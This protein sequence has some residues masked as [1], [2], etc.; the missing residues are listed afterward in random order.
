[1][2]AV[3]DNATC[4]SKRVSFEIPYKYQTWGHD[5]KPSFGRQILGPLTD[6]LFVSH[7]N[8][9]VNFHKWIRLLPLKRRAFSFGLW[10]CAPAVLRSSCEIFLNA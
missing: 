2:E 8:G 6:V 3:I 4:F 1:M 7:A 5:V 9:N 10:L